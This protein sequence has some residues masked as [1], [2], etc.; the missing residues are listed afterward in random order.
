MT[1]KKAMILAAG[2][3]K[4]MLPLTEK[5]PKALLKVGSKNLLERSIELLIRI[6]ID[7]LVINTHYLSYEIDNF[8]KNKNY[9]I[10]I[11][12]IKEDELLDTGGGILNATISFENDPFFVLNP[13]TIWNKNYYEELKILENLYLENNKPVLLLV[14]KIKS[15]DKSFKGDFN[16]KKNK[17]IIRETY[18]QYIFTGAQIINRSIFESI[19]KNFF[20]MNLIWN[21]MIKEKKLLGQVSNQTFFHINNLKVYEELNKLK[22]ID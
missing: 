3:G 19:K 17:Y 10:S 11:S 8:L 20:S 7:E 13:D 16:F 14:D 5:T 9:G 4:R 6:G 12:T 2:F 18:N 1:I 22:F 15:H 21:Q